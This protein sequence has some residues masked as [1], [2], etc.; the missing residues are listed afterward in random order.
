LPTTQ[1]VT[2]P[3]DVTYSPSRTYVEYP[4]AAPPPV[5]NVHISYG[6]QLPQHPNPFQTAV[7]I[8]PTQTPHHSLYGHG[9]MYPS[10]PLQLPPSPSHHHP[11]APYVQPSVPVV[12]EE[13]SSSTP[14][15]TPA[16][17]PAPSTAVLSSAVSAARGRENNTPSTADQVDTTDERD[18]HGRGEGPATT[19]GRFSRVD[20]EDNGRS[21]REW[22]GH[23]SVRRGSQQGNEADEEGWTGVRRPQHAYHPSHGP[24][25]FHYERRVDHSRLS[26][27]WQWATY[28]VTGPT[29][30]TYV[31]SGGCPRLDMSRWLQYSMSSVKRAERYW[32]LF[33]QSHQYFV[34][35][36]DIN[37]GRTFARDELE[38][39]YVDSMSVFVNEHRGHT[40]EELMSAARNMSV[41]DIPLFTLGDS[42]LSRWWNS[43]RRWRTLVKEM[44]MMNKANA[45]V[46][47]SSYDCLVAGS[48]EEM[49]EMF[50][51]LP[52]F[53]NV[54]RPR[55]SG[56]LQ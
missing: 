29:F 7:F 31:N 42:L 6:P 28:P 10:Q 15:P 48:F 25:M 50:P 18:V 32:G 53:W 35:P 49:Q 27:R 40:V 36:Q 45:C 16:G 43:P 44:D 20:E 23:G 26:G 3:T 47:A 9:H 2:T 38:V 1:P 4:T 5:F 11:Q 34:I 12:V 39:L 19:H 54:L 56:G 33:F 41:W 46:S 21:T 13:L 22:R 30:S 17:Q 37:C 51:P 24:R 55:S 8:S 52:K 14:T